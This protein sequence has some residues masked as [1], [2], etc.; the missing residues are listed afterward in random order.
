MGLP[1]PERFTARDIRRTITNLITDAGVRPED[2]DQ[3]QSHDQTG[4]VKKHYDRHTHLPRK[5]AAIRLYDRRLSHVLTRRKWNS[6][7]SLAR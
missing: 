2:N 7:L 4:V 5:R 1:V 6:K 3:L